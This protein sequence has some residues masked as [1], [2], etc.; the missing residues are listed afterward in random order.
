MCEYVEYGVTLTI[1]KQ[2]MHQLLTI[3]LSFKALNSYIILSMVIYCI[4][5]ALVVTARVLHGSKVECIY[6]I[7]RQGMFSQPSM[8][9]IYIVKER[10]L[11][12]SLCGRAAVC[13]GAGCFGG[14]SYALW[15]R[16]VHVAVRN[17]TRKASK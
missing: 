17:Y 7:Y 1:I 6:I 13:C 11:Y 3:F 16:P 4:D 5:F 15:H 2:D 8:S 10:S 14:C 12:I 9:I